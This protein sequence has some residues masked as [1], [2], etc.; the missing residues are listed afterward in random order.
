MI[1][2]TWWNWLALLFSSGG[3]WSGLSEGA[4]L[5]ATRGVRC[6]RV[7][8]FDSR[9][10]TR[11]QS[12]SSLLSLFSISVSLLLS[13]SLAELLLPASGTTLEFSLRFTGDRDWSESAPIFSFSSMF[14]IFF[15]DRTK[16]ESSSIPFLHL[17]YL[18]ASP[19]LLFCV[20]QEQCVS[21]DLEWWF[22]IDWTVPGIWLLG[23]ITVGRCW[24]TNSA[25][26]EFLFLFYS[27]VFLM[28]VLGN[29]DD[30]DVLSFAFKVP[31]LI[32]WVAVVALSHCC[33]SSSSCKV[34]PRRIFVLW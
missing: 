26:V 8:S 15:F 3:C 23:Y 22:V 19:I 6:L 14:M 27:P 30:D 1:T 11:G 7:I 16:S 10:L 29:D 4:L 12:S 17:Y 20:V 13:L 25:E 21:R 2:G 5:W 32:A 33:C 31:S 18:V 24:N 34:N 9:E 28:I